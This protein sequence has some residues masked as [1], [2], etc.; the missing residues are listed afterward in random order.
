MMVMMVMTH[1]GHDGHGS[2]PINPYSLRTS[3][4]LAILFFCEMYVV[5]GAL[6]LIPDMMSYG[7]ILLFMPGQF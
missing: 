6:F 2:P 7:Y 5:Y 4:L 1:D 3:S